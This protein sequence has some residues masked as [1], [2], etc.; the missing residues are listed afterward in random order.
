MAASAGGH[1]LFRCHLA[2]SPV[3]IAL[4]PIVVLAV[5]AVAG[6]ASRVHACRRAAILKLSGGRKSLVLNLF[7]RG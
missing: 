1:R 5:V 4:L 3:N 7:G 2:R 6:V